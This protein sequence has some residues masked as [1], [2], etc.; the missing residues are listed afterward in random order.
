MLEQYKILPSLSV[1]NSS[2]SLIFDCEFKFLKNRQESSSII[3][4][5]SLKKKC[6]SNLSEYFFVFSAPVQNWGWNIQLLQNQMDSSPW[7]PKS[8]IPQSFSRKLSIALEMPPNFDLLLATATEIQ[9][10]EVQPCSLNSVMIAYIIW[11]SPANS[12]KKIKML[13]SAELR[14]TA[15]LKYVPDLFCWSVIWRLIALMSVILPSE[16]A[17]AL[18][19]HM[20]QVVWCAFFFFPFPLLFNLSKTPSWSLLRGASHPSVQIPVCMAS[21][22]PSHRSAAD[23]SNFCRNDSQP[24]ARWCPRLPEMSY[25]YPRRGGTFLQDNL[26]FW[27]GSKELQEQNTKYLKCTWILGYL[28]P[29]IHLNQTEYLQYPVLYYSN[30]LEMCAS[31]PE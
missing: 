14:Y 21:S 6:A 22:L 15:L 16:T 24:S 31:F 3:L 9:G 29:Y 1:F 27:D 2:L 28:D 10:L 19:L 7:L 25:C 4:P 5:L 20:F 18:L 13:P 26:S 30:I 12:P 23:R 8:N 11:F 17:K